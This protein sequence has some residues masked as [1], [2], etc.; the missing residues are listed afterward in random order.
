MEVCRGEMSA[1][2]IERSVFGVEAIR[3]D[4]LHREHLDDDDDKRMGI[5]GGKRCANI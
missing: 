1:A 5:R 3:D 4:L 2:H